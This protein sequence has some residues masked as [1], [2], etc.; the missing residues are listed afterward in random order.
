VYSNGSVT[1][2]YIV[3]RDSAGTDIIEVVRLGD[4]LVAEQLFE[5]PVSSFGPCIP[6]IAVNN[7]HS[8]QEWM[9][10]WN[11]ANNMKFTTMVG[12]QDL[13]P[14]IRNKLLASSSYANPEY[15]SIAWN[16]DLW[17]NSSVP[18]YYEIVWKESGS[19]KFTEIETQVNSA[20]RTIHS[21]TWIDPSLG[22]QGATN[23][24][25]IYRPTWSGMN[26]GQQAL[27]APS[28]SAD[29]GLGDRING[30]SFVIGECAYMAVEIE[31]TTS[32]WPTASKIVSPFR[33]NTRTLSA[34]YST[35][36]PSNVYSRRFIVKEYIGGAWFSTPI[37]YSMSYLTNSYY[38]GALNPSI[39]I[40]SGYVDITNGK[41]KKDYVRTVFQ[42]NTY[43]TRV[44]QD[45]QGQN[46]IK[47]FVEGQDPNIAAVAFHPDIRAV[48]TDVPRWA[49][50]Y[51]DSLGNSQMNLQKT[52][53]EEEQVSMR[54]IIVRQDSGA[55]IFGISNIRWIDKN[56]V[57]TSLDWL[58]KTDSTGSDWMYPIHVRM[59]TTSFNAAIADTVFYEQELF[60]AYRELFGDKEIKVQFRASENNQVVLERNVRIEDFPEDSSLYELTAIDI[61]SIGNR[62]VYMT[63]DVSEDID[64]ASVDV[65]QLYGL[66]VY[67]PEMPKSG[68]QN[69]PP[70]CVTLEQNYPNPFNPSTEITYG[71]PEL[72]RVKLSVYDN[73]GREVK[74]LVNEYKEAGTYTVQFNAE[75]LPSGM[76][77][78]KID[79]PTGTLSRKMM[80]MK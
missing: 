56:D 48:F 73:L 59:Q 39:G 8:A 29:S 78:Y 30:Y 28:L 1:V 15:P 54:Q 9:A 44:A 62:T 60:T 19:I 34:V 47:W 40:K 67:E 65:I 20:G 53:T 71:V 31:N 46:R 24:Y 10:T 49:Q 37:I 51:A 7:Q 18:A 55:A 45:L 6:V 21:S 63:I 25:F 32:A 33:M 5:A 58:K 17:F 12:N 13:N 69:K 11:D 38:T 26:P 4:N 68:E 70:A 75:K 36:L 41:R 27:N 57:I 72:G 66:L 2:P 80:L 35:T 77:L 64:T 42:S 76:Y 50:N 16:C 3:Y 22:G 74:V 43:E 52:T 14:P 23:A 79:T 61:R